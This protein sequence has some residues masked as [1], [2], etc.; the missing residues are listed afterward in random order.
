[1][2]LALVIAICAVA[3]VIV[4]AIGHVNF[5]LGFVAMFPV[6][7]ATRWLLDRVLL[8]EKPPKTRCSAGQ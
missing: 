7:G 5:L 4:V 8:S 3:G 6:Y 2:Q 1:M